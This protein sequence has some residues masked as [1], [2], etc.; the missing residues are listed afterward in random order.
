MIVN[1]V[2]FYLE[3]LIKIYKMQKINS[4]DSFLQNYDFKKSKTSYQSVSWYHCGE[5]IDLYQFCQRILQLTSLP[6]INIIYTLI[7]INRF[8]KK[9]YFELDN[10]III[11]LIL[12]GNLISSKIL[13]DDFYSNNFLSFLGGIDIF[14]LN[15]LE[16]EF[17]LCCEGY[18]NVSS[19]E[20]IE[21]YRHIIGYLKYHNLID[22]KL[23][24]TFNKNFNSNYLFQER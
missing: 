15:K 5:E 21:T 16:V 1:L 13:D 23:P 11:R 22:N 4:L 3:D 7:I 10:N 17:L 2:C 24:I 6:E 8:L 18:L 9:T 14:T 19:E 12:I 20:L